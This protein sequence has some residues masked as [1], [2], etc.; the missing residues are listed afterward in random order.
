MHGLSN[1]YIFADTF[2]QEGPADPA[3]ASVALSKPHTGVGS[4]GLILIDPA[5]G[6]DARL[7]IFNAD[8][9]AAETCGNGI[10]CAARY[11]YDSGLCRR[12]SMTILTGAGLNAVRLHVEGGAVRAVTV[13]MGAPQSIRSGVRLRAAGR[14]LT[15]V[16]VSMGNPH[17]VTFGEDGRGDAFYTLGPAFER[18][19]AFPER[20]NIEFTEVLAPDRLRVRVWERGSGETLACGSGACAALV[21]AA[22]DGRSGRQARVELPGGSLDIAWR[23]SDGHVLMTGPATPVFRGEVG[24]DI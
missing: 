8:G 4:D 19:E 9:S 22:S 24:T 5:D 15:F 7:R 16:C 18:H 23:T 12:E 20:A 13:D 11:L 3:A 21:A 2:T 17:A 10:R 6:A 14:T 1:D